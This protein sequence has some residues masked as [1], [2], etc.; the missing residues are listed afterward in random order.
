LKSPGF[1]I[2]GELIIMTR[3]LA[4]ET[5]GLCGSV[6]LLESCHDRVKTAGQLMLPPTQRTAQALAPSSRRLLQEVDWLPQSIDLVAVAAGPGSFTGLRIGM[7]MAKTWAYA[8]GAK[9]L[10]V[11]TLEVLAS[12]IPQTSGPLH[13]VLNAQREEL[14][15]ARFLPVV[16]GGW[17]IVEPTGILAIPAWLTSL[18]PGDT[19]TGPGL[20]H[21][22]NALPK[23]VDI[24]DQHAWQPV[25]ENVGKV[26][27]ERFRRGEEDDLWKLVPDYYRLSAAEE[28]KGPD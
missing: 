13:T 6:A 11:N 12:Q 22:A 19:V 24:A 2:Q 5:S 20:T 23:G 4:V 7:T 27:W 9:I 21:L 25:A 8:V 17:D 28:R 1:A 14:F 10:G 16:S 15:A 3:I 18:S 26:G